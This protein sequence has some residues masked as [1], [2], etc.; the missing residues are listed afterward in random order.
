RYDFV[1]GGNT[2]KYEFHVDG[3]QNVSLFGPNGQLTEYATFAANGSKTQDRFFTNGHLTQ[4]ND[5]LSNG[6]IIVH[7]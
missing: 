1:E 3:T 4:E 6:N 5:F 7:M 2:T